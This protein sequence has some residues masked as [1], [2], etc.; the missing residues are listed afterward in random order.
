MEKLGFRPYL[1]NFKPQTKKELS[2]Y[3]PWHFQ[4]WADNFYTHVGGFFWSIKFL[5]LFSNPNSFFSKLYTNVKLVL[6]LPTASEDDE[7]DVE[8]ENSAASLVIEHSLDDGATWTPR[9]TVNLRSLKTDNAIIN[10]LG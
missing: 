1:G 2:S 4:F 3:H 6:Y 5:S 9:A 8:V 7:L 10:P